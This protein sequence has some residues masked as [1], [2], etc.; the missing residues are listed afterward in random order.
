MIGYTRDN[1]EFA[2]IRKFSKQYWW[3]Y[4]VLILVLIVPLAVVCGVFNKR[5]CDVNVWITIVTCIVAYI[6]SSFLG[7][8]VF[9]N[10]WVQI[11]I[12]QKK[13]EVRLNI[14]GLAYNNPEN[15]YFVPYSKDM[16]EQ[17]QYQYRSCC[18]Y[19]N[20]NN[21]YLE[22]VVENLT[23]EMPIDICIEGIYAVNEQNKIQKA[24][25]FSI[26]SDARIDVPLDYKQSVTIYIGTSKELIPNDYYLKREHHICFIVIKVSTAD[27]KS[28]YRIVEYVLGQTL[29]TNSG[30]KE[31]TE[32]KYKQRCDKY[33]SPVFLTKYHK[34][35][36]KL[37]NDTE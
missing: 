3:L 27:G 34:T 31:L 33:G 26:I 2:S 6:G 19:N 24:I 23:K 4:V 17:K 21:N 8:V 13:D 9:F 32:K 18:G 30:Q 22:L 10:S 35:L 5:L 29:G 20:L 11:Q 37:R 28:F 36:L 1:M 7:V 14:I 12:Q 16:I 25:D 15:Y